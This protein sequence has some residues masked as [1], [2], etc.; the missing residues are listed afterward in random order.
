M[1]Q[2]AERREFANL[3]WREQ[4]G[5]FK[6]SIINLKIIN[7]LLNSNISV[8][9]FQTTVG[10]SDVPVNPSE[11]EPPLEAP[12][13]SIHTASFCLNNNS[14][15]NAKTYTL[16]LRVQSSPNSCHNSESDGKII[17]I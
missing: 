11:N 7:F 12:T 16:H 9:E 17:I 5:K 15:H 1:P 8:L 13:I 3:S 10:V 2:E 6:V 4:T 14:G